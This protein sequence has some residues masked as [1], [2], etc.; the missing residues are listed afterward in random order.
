MRKSMMRISSFLFILAIVLYYINNLFALKRADGIYGVTKLYELEDNSIDVLVLGSS[1]AF[2][3]INTGTLWDEHGIAAYILAGSYQQLWYTYY[4]L[5]EALKTQKPRLIVLEAYMTTFEGD[6]YSVGTV[7]NT[8]GLRWSKDKL[9]AIR[10]STPRDEWG[11]YI[12]GYIQYHTRYTDLSRADFL[13]N[14]GNPLYENWKGYGC[15]MRTASYDN[16][17]VENVGKRNPLSSKSEVYYRKILELARDKEIPLLIVISPYAGI[18]ENAQAVFN[19]A[20]DIAAEYDVEFI[21]YNL[22][23]REMGIDYST[24]AADADHLNYR[25]SQKYTHAL[26]AY[27]ADNYDIPDRRGDERYESWEADSQYISVLIKNQ[28]L[29]EAVEK[30]E[31]ADVVAGLMNQEYL[32]FVSNQGDSD[33][34]I[35]DVAVLFDTLGIPE[36]KRKGILCVNNQQG[37]LYAS[38][39]GEY[40]KDFRLDYHDV[41]IT[42]TLDKNTQRYSNSVILDNLSYGEVDNGINI[43]VYNPITQNVVD[44]FGFDENG[45]IVQ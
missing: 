5:N 41:Y 28:E 36:D 2:E 7:V 32:V 23:Y 15:N 30:E 42:R 25:G 45:G 16:P 40:H 6:Y 10:V 38:G 13:K 4:Y 26:G 17:D 34:S 43:M 21:D 22:R 18:T 9:D 11:E 27:I 24:D 8:Y 3:D 35:P 19:M 33:I 14:Q 29:V 39:E 12:L 1:H 31:V 20:S 44:S 37:I